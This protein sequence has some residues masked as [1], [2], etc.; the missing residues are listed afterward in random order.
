MKKLEL[1]MYFFVPYQLTG[2]QQAIQSGHAALEYAHKYKNDKQFIDFIDNWKTWIILNGGTTNSKLRPGIIS[3]RKE[4]DPY[5]G[6]LDNLYA[7]LIDWNMNHKKDLISHSVFS[8]PDLNDALT[9]ICFI[10]DERV[11]NY[12]DYPDIGNYTY[13]EF[14][15]ADLSLKLLM[16]SKEEQKEKFLHEYNK[17]EK[18]MGGKKNV[19]LRNLLKGKKLA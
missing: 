4:E 15:N 1:R 8:E 14:K 2:I 6:T 16:M 18:F 19:F 13:P 10:C 12:E 11:F 7:K 9:A 5:Q 3:P 17:W